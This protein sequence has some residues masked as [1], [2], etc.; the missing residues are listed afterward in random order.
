MKV[1]MAAHARCSQQ[2]RIFLRGEKNLFN[3][4]LFALP[5]S[6]LSLLSIGALAPE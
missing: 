1:S 5:C 3:P 4:S 2:M 6:L